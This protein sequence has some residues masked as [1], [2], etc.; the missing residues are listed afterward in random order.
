M[1]P[2]CVGV[3][4]GGG[5]PICLRW[6]FRRLLDCKPLSL[7]SPFNYIG[8]DNTANPRMKTATLPSLMPD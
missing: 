3:G 1:I 7:G 4:G 6:V 2:R 8:R 5:L